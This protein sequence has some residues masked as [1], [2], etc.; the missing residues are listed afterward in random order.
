MSYV[1]F[2]GCSLDGTAKDFHRSTLAVAAKLGLELP[3][4]QD[5]ICCGST[6][7]HSSDPLLADAL[8]AQNLFA[9]G[10]QTVAVACAAC[11]SRLKMANHHIAG[12][13]AVRAKVARL[14]GGDY[15]GLTPVRHLLEILCRDIGRAR[16]AAAI[17]RPLAGL[18][19]ACYY[20]CLLSRPPEVTNFDDAE[21]PTLMDQLMETAGATPIDWPHK[22]E[23][24]GAS[25]SITDSSIVLRTEQ[26]DPVDGP[27]RR[28]GLHRDRLPAVPAQPGHA[29]EGYRDQVR[30]AVQPAGV[31][32]HATAGPGDGLLGERSVARQP[33]GGPV[34]A[35]G[36]QGDLRRRGTTM[37]GNNG[38]GH[39]RQAEAVGAVLVCG[40]GITGMQASLDLAESG[41]KVYLLDSS[42][43][44]GGRMAQLDKTF[45]TGDCAMCILSPKLVECARNKN[46]EII[47][48]ADVEGISGEPGN[49]KVK[50]R[51]N[52]RYVDLDKCNACGDCTEA[53][54]V[55][56]PERIRPPAGHPQG[57]LPPLSA[58]HPERLR[59]LEGR[60][61]RAV[62]GR[63]APRA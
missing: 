17:R 21:N 45:P 13:A 43:A 47:T 20:G 31:L 34:W 5:W 62:Q 10:G 3:E 41:F 8:P 38:N 4:L 27:G 56:L 2:P 35:A 53:C 58:G 28:G 42:P 15:D 57:H 39:E 32:L 6:A 11:Y 19:V 33:G 23:C 44:I 16:I 30:A 24:C 60:R 37:S 59:D 26:P 22:T 7:A 51:Q 25:F 61:A 55:D 46:I 40:A 48:L 18:K 36:I 29:A 63:P 9:A 52:P 1:F 50:I 49:F 14:V 54:P 12:D